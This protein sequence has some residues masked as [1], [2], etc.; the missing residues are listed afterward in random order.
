MTFLTR[1]LSA[2]RQFVTHKL[3]TSTEHKISEPQRQK[4]TIILTGRF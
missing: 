1:H 4:C 2:T 3:V